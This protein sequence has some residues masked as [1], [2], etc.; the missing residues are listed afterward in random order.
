[1]IQ[2]IN[3]NLQEIRGTVDDI[4]FKN[5]ENGYIVL[6]L[7]CDNRFLETVT[8]ELGDIVEGEKLIVRGTYTTSVKYG[9]QFKAVMCE[10]TLPTEAY[11]IRKYLGSGIIKGLGPSMAKKIVDKF[12]EDS[13]KII[14]NDPYRL[15][16]IKGI[17][18][19][20]ALYISSEFRRLCGVKDVIEFLQK[21]GIAPVSAVNVWKRY[22]TSSI[23]SVKD[24]PFLL[25]E[26][27]IDVDFDVADEI[28]REMGISNNDPNR[29]KAG[30]AYVLR[31]N[32]YVGHTCLPIARLEKC[33]CEN[34]EVE[35]ED[36]NEMLNEGI[37]EDR[38]KCL[39]F[40]KHLFV[41][42]TVYFTAETYAAKKLTEMLKLSAPLNKDFSEE[43]AGVEWSEG[44]KYETLQKAA[45]NGCLGNNLFIL[46][47]G[48][49]TGK[50]TTLN[51]VI[52]LCKAKKK[53]IALAA[54]T[55]RAA[56]RMADLT[57]EK[58][59]TIHRLLE[60]DFSK[61]DRLAFKHNEKNPLS[62]DVIIIDEMSM[63]DVL[64][65]EAL[66]RAIKHD[67]KLIMVG[68]SN[69]L[70]SVGAGNVLRD[71]LVSGAIPSVELKEIFRQA[72][73]SLIITNAHKIV[74]GEL[75]QLDDR[76][77]DFFFMP[78]EDDSDTAR[79]VLELAKTRLPRTYDY[80]PI[81]DIQVLSP[82]R[83]GVAGT[84]E[85]NRSLQLALNPPE[86]GKKEVRFMDFMYRVGDKVMQ[87]K[88]DY[89]VVWKKDGESGSGI[90]NGDIGIVVDAD[91]YSSSL[92]IDF[93]GRIATY[94]SDML[95]KLDLAYA[96]TI[97]KS[98]GS[99]YKAVILPLSSVT[100]NL[101]YRNLLYT[102]VTRAKEILIIVGKRELVAEM[103][104]NEKKTLR[105]SCLRP[106]L[107]LKNRKI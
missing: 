91:T 74:R 47:G 58:A 28:A 102:G 62:A 5:S 100:H 14:E 80:S 12:E 78:C 35:P 85:L 31:E 50:T 40:G 21:Y 65:F 49:G 38:F 101:L 27:G 2:E 67:A 103:V 89:D 63:V 92:K 37:D 90:F 64:L 11:E 107:E 29:V 81:D 39:S 8:G 42:L 57:G 7:N 33:V 53:R 59:K 60:V 54:P 43:I 32:S 77:R 45:I 79:I 9:K 13:F 72:A 76:K 69:Q 41:Y 17:T 55:G 20:R 26:N 96:V 70:P 93:D 48:P 46:T 88:N 51:A 44:I 106:M 34:L 10:R 105:Y 23:A 18:T 98:Q 4:I 66:L 97:H 84:K 30:I 15:A 99:E 24:N 25:C 36:F 104:N 19:D 61:D 95:V 94:T 73:E 86:R 52:Q 3:Q 56:K 71:M 83:I 16:E 75:P 82:T 6:T 22:E 1:M 68:D 87:I